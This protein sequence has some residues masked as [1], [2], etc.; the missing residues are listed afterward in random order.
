MENNDKFTS[1]KPSDKIVWLPSNRLS[2][3]WISLSSYMYDRGSFEKPSYTF[4]IA[5]GAYE[6]CNATTLRQYFLVTITIRSCVVRGGG[7]DQTNFPNVFLAPA[8]QV[9]IR[10][11]LGIDVL[12]HCLHRSRDDRTRTLM[13]SCIDVKTLTTSY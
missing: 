2:L 13:L 11:A 5:V 9:H 10:G 8:F 3:K 12:S 6:K 7:S 1:T 4:A